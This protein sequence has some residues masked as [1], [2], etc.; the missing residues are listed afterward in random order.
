[1]TVMKKLF[2]VEYSRDSICKQKAERDVQKYGAVH[3]V[4][5]RPV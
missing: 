2:M 1:M 5:C 3:D 4:K